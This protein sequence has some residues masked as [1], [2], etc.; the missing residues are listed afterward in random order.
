MANEQK[1]Q[2][3]KKEILKSDPKPIKKG[4]ELLKD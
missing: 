2:D 1:K 4:Q 3:G